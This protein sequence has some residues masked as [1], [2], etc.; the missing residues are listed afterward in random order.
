MQQVGG[1]GL[2]K[3]QEDKKIKKV[4]LCSGKIYFDLVEAREKIKK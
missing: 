4:V 2:I 1:Y 3:L